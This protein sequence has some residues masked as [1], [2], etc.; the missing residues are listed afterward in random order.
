MFRM[1]IVRAETCV[2]AGNRWCV[3]RRAREPE[4]QETPRIQTTETKEKTEKEIENTLRVVQL[5]S[6]ASSSAP[7]GSLSM[8]P[9]VVDADG[10]PS[11]MTIS[12]PP[13]AC[14]REYSS[15]RLFSS[16]VRLARVMRASVSYTD[17]VS[18]ST[19][20][21]LKQN[22]LREE[23]CLLYLRPE[24]QSPSLWRARRTRW[25]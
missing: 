14:A 13:S 22:N 23:R 7:C 6:I 11:S 15:S 19:R 8:S 21:V 17:D 24:Q 4:K 5:S 9:E 1:M 16:A 2:C 18:R 3:L 25:L 10:R 12:F 20:R